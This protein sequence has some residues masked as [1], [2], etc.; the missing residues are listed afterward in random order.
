MNVDSLKIDGTTYFKLYIS[1]PV[2]SDRGYMV[3]QDYWL[4][5]E[6]NNGCGCDGS[7]YIGDNAYFVCEKCQESA[8]VTKWIYS[9]T[10]HSDVEINKLEK[11]DPILVQAV[12]TA[13]QMVTYTGIAWLSTFLKN[14]NLTIE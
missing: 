13:G 6:V 7:I 1:C 2:C 12:S 14:M 9:C 10:V 5:S 11:A 3:A 4:H 8:H